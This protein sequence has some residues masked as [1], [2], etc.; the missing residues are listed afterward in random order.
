MNLKS[1][2][3]EPQAHPPVSYK[4]KLQCKKF[5]MCEQENVSL[6]LCSCQYFFQTIRHSFAKQQIEGNNKIHHSRLN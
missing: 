3:E 1:A 4:T 2:L 6:Q 5:Q